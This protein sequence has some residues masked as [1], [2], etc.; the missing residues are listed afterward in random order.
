MT[1]THVIMAPMK[2]LKQFIKLIKGLPFIETKAATAD[3][4]NHCAQQHSSTTHSYDDAYLSHS[5]PNC[6]RCV[7]NHAD[8]DL[9]CCIELPIQGRGCQDKRKPDS[10]RE[11][12]YVEHNL[13][14]AALD[15]KPSL[16]IVQ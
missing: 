4:S 1:V 15:C 14:A 8:G 13:A 2:F 16:Y 10:I 11:H 7:L 6:G 3:D 5:K 9:G 12:V